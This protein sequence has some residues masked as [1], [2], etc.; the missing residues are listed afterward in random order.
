[1]TT[2]RWI[3][4]IVWLLYIVLLVRFC[5]DDYAANCCGVG[6]TTATGPPAVEET[7]NPYPLAFQEKLAIPFTG[8]AIDS[9]IE[10]I[11]SGEEAGNA[12]EVTGYYYASEPAPEGFATMGFARAESIRQR[13]FTDIPA[14]RIRIRSRQLTGDPPADQRYFEAA[15]FSWVANENSLDATV[16]VLKDRI[17]IRFPYN[18]TEKV[19]DEEVEQYLTKLATRV[20]DTGEQIVLTGHT[21][22]YGSEAFNMTL[23]Q[24]RAQAIRRILLEKGVPEGQID[25]LSRGENDPTDSNDTEEGRHNNRRVE[26][27]FLKN[28]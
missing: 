20:K 17:L 12:L 27:R 14:D 7:T 21:D 26:V 18:S 16:E 9:L 1:M 15:D 2:T 11:K 8:P 28:E 19:Y 6:D 5:S 23:G 13:F 10:A 3:I 24:Q 4:L 25:V 22:N